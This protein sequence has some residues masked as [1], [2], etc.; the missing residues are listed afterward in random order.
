MVALSVAV[1]AV[2]LL[3][4]QVAVAPAMTTTPPA[5]EPMRAA[6]PGAP[7]GAGPDWREHPPVLLR[8]KAY[9]LAY[10]KVLQGADEAT[11]EAVTR[12][13]EQDAAAVARG[14]LPAVGD[15][16]NQHARA[17]LQMSTEQRGAL[18]ME[19]VRARAQRVRDT[20]HSG[21]TSQLF[22]R[23]NHRSH[24]EH[25]EHDELV[26]LLGHDHTRPRPNHLAGVLSS[27]MDD[28]AMDMLR[29]IDSDSDGK[30]HRSEFVKM[31]HAEL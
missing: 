24:D 12:L 30:V 3:L 6:L 16:G 14:E 26:S 17:M 31:M 27:V 15:A 2:H 29:R 1:A 18:E 9:S 5:P 10:Q 7:P 11:L 21:D 13:A 19:L 22:D 28:I 4:L 25:L 23:L 20:D 8:R